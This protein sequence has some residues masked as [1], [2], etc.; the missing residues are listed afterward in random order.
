MLTG[1]L[2]LVDRVCTENLNSG[3]LVVKSAKEGV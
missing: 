3:V 2:N 1:C